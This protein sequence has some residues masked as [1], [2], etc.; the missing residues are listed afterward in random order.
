[1]SFREWL[2]F[3]KRISIEQF[4]KMSKERQTELEMEYDTEYGG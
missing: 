2:L 1:M 3:I 4:Y